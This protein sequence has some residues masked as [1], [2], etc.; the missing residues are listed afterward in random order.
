MFD[1]NILDLIGFIVGAS[2]GACMPQP[3]WAK[4]IQD[5]AVQKFKDYFIKK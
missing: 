3:A 2:A 4:A 1:F 5:F